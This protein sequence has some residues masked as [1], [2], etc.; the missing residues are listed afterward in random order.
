MR[1]NNIEVILKQFY[2]CTEFELWFLIMIFVLVN[3]SGYSLD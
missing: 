2:S 1:I 3:F